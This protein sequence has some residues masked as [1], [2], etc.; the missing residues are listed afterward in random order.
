MIYE[1][2]SDLTPYLVENPDNESDLA[3][4]V[5]KSKTPESIFKKFQELDAEIFEITGEHEF[6][7]AD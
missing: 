4:V 6:A 5:I 2:D 1:L 7:F 3:Y